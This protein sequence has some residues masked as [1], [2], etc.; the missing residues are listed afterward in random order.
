MALADGRRAKCA[1]R[2]Q[3]NAGISSE[4]AKPR[5]RRNEVFA[6][7][8]PELRRTGDIKKKEPASCDAGST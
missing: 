8:K 1:A 5:E 4:A 3:N 7:R 2:D 6:A